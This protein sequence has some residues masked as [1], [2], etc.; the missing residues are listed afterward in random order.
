MD[1]AEA[2]LRRRRMG[3]HMSEKPEEKIDPI[4]PDEVEGHGIEE[5]DSEDGA[6]VESVTFTGICIG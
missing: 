4:V 5:D 3:C 1:A 6:A 2:I